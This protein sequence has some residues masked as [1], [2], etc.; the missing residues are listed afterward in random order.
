MNGK[1]GPFARD[2]VVVAFALVAITSTHTRGQE[3]A[4]LS[5]PSFTPT[6]VH[7]RLPGGIPWVKPLGTQTREKQTG[8]KLWATAQ[9]VPAGWCLIGLFKI[10]LR[11][12]IGCARSGP[13]RRW[14]DGC[15][16]FNPERDLYLLGEAR[17][18][19]LERRGRNQPASR[20][21]LQETLVICTLGSPAPAFA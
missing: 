14:K 5:G 9:R 17:E 12:G 3:P 19:S 2:A 8:E 11:S 7:P 6:A 21:L 18:S 1:N 20:F 10:L 4:T 15:C 13:E 16:H